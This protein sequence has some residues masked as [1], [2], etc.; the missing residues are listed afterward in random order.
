MVEFRGNFQISVD[1]E[2]FIGSSDDPIT[3]SLEYFFDVGSLASL[4]QAL[5]QKDKLM[6][7]AGV[8]FPIG[9]GEAFENID[10][11]GNPGQINDCNSFGHEKNIPD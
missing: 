10:A 5:A 7:M 9:I 11:F 1:I 6:R 3:T 8:V 4:F 2:S